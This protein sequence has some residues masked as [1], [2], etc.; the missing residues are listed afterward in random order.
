M[1]EIKM[2]KYNAFRWIATISLVAVLSLVMA[3]AC[4]SKGS[5][6]S[7]YNNNP[8]PPP[9]PGG[10]GGG[11][12]GTA[13]SHSVSVM[14]FA[15]S[16]AGITIAHGD[17]VVWTNNDTITHTVTSNT[18][19]VLNSGGIAPGMTYRHVF[20]TAGVYDY[21]CSIHTTMHGAITVQ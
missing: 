13:H 11:G 16:P 21:H 6:T 17:T 19:T 7:P 9:P 5:T 2:L 10:G 20:A 3:M 15:F 4:G 18:G 1:K 14:Y 12:G 8:P